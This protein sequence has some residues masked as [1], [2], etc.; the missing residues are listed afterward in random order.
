VRI[1][2]TRRGLRVL[3]RGLVLSEVLARPGPTNTLFDVLAAAVAGLA[4]GP[5]VAVLGFAAGGVVAPLRA[6]GWRHPLAAVDLDVTGETH[7]RHLSDAWAGR[8]S[9]ARAD[10]AEWLERRGAPFDAVLED[11]SVLTHFGVVTKPRTTLDLLP[12]LIARRLAPGGV[13]IV[14]LLPIPGIRW[15]AAVA[16]VRAPWRRAVVV[17]PHDYENRVVIAGPRLPPAAA[18]SRILRERLRAIG[19][20]QAARLAVRSAGRPSAR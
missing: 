18:V 14:N 5:R 17:R 19:S 15:S 6:M 7:F 11:L 8:V 9:V 1:V 12:A 10:A 4:R 3:E 13:A 20:D 2:R 16:R